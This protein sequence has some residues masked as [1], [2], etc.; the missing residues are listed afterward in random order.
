M[1]ENSI[2][3][4]SL[5]VEIGEESVV[6]MNGK[7]TNEMELDVFMQNW[8]GSFSYLWK[9]EPNFKSLQ[10]GDE[11]QRVCLGCKISYLKSIMKESF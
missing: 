8:T 6:L 1:D 7:S 9:P 4:S 10:L 3:S 11:N 2:L 5:L